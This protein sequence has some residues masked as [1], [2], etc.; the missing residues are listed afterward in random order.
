MLRGTQSLSTRRA[1]IEIAS[2]RY[3]DRWLVALLTESVDRNSVSLIIPKTDTVALLT[4][5]VD[6]NSSA[7]TLSISNC[8]RSP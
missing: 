4:E 8:G 2:A 5:S 1:W 6:R 3:R 7:T